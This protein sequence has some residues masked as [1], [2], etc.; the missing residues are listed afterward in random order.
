MRLPWEFL[1]GHMKWD[2]SYSIGQLKPDVV[3]E[4]W[5]RAQDAGQY[6]GDNYV[7]IWFPPANGT[8]LMKKDSPDIYW[9]R[10]SGSG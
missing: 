10:L 1:P 7:A 9:D 3:F 4:L 8:V 6:M 5:L 2:Y